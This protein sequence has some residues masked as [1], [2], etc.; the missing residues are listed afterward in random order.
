[1]NQLLGNHQPYDVILI[2]RHHLLKPYLGITRAVD[3]ISS[4]LLQLG[5]TVCI[6]AEGKSETIIDSNS[7]L[8]IISIPS[9]GLSPASMMQLG[10]PHPISGWLTK[11]AGYLP[12]GKLVICPVVGL[13]SMIFKKT[14]DLGFFKVI[15]LYTPYSRYSVLGA[16]YFS[17]Q[18][19]SLKSADLVIGNSKTIL[20]K[21]KTK[22]SDTVRVIPNLSSLT[23][24]LSGEKREFQSDLVWIGALTYRKGVD[25]LLHFLIKNRGRNSVLVVWSEGRFHLVPLFIISLLE[26]FGWC[27]LRNNVSDKDLSIILGNIKVLLSTTRFES[28]GMTLVEAASH[29]KGTIGI[30]APGIDETLPESSKGALYFKKVSH[31]INFL[32]DSDFESVA[33]DLGRNAMSFGESKYSQS[34]ISSLWKDAIANH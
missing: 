34:T 5:L 27:E 30:K 16:L 6:L 9:Q 15:T 20:N 24:C 32:R 22:E 29:G 19:N 4:I 1:M 31:I 12:L 18:R 28:F 14:E 8:T 25:R 13:Q 26:R 10:V 11:L 23:P 2:S 3:Q 33:I 17:L 7:R 21:F